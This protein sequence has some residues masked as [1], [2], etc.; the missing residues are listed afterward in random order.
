[1]GEVIWL[2]SEEESHFKVRWELEN[3]REARDGT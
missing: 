1:V 3:Q 2:R